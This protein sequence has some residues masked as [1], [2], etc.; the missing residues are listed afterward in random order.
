MAETSKNK[1][2]LVVICGSTRFVEDMKT[3]ETILTWYGYAVYAP[4]KCNLKEPNRLWQ[5]P[6]EFQAGAMRLARSHDFMIDK[7]DWVL[8]VGDY[9]GHSVNQEI[10]YAKSIGKPVKFMSAYLAQMYDGNLENHLS[11]WVEKIN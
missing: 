7:C 3:L 6:A 1:V 2:E 5:D 10:V 4:T 11:S 9:S 8:V